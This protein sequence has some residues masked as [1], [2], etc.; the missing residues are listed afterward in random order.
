MVYVPGGSPEMVYWPT[1]FV[2]KVLTMPWPVTMTVAP[3]MAAP[4]WSL[5]LPLI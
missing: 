3:G 5:T 2:P 4:D 1:S